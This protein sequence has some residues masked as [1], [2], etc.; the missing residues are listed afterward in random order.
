[1]S[2]L[3]RKPV[4]P[5]VAAV[6]LALSSLAGCATP[7]GPGYLV[8]RQEIR[9]SFQ[10]GPR[11][12]VQITAEYRLRN[13]GNQSLDSLDL[14]LPGGRYRPSLFAFSWDGAALPYNVSPDNPRDTELRFG[15]L[16]KVGETHAL[17]ISYELAPSSGEDAVGFAADAFYLPSLGW[18]PQLPQARGVFGFGGVPPDRWPLVVTLPAEF[19]V[20]CSGGRVK[21]SPKGAAVEY[22][23]EQ[24]S[25]DFTPFVIAGK[26]VE[27]QQILASHQI[28]HVWTR[29]KLDVAQLAGA[30]EVMS[31][32]LATYDALFG[33]SKAKQRVPVW[34]V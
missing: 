8:E 2:R 30:G 34:I 28:V 23:F 26:Y 19:L 11:P 27:T 7:F 22:A 32:A 10:S 21:R 25:A 15:Q 31:R 5:L 24:T 3:P 33:S 12:H 13:T 14:R 6:L 16:W 9:V 17:E 1:M 18:T 29:G 4:S 20:H